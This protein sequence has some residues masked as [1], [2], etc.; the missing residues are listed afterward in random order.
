M[1]ANPRGTSCVKSFVCLLNLTLATI[2][3]TTFFNM[4]VQIDKLFVFLFENGEDNFTP[5]RSI[6]NEWYA[7]DMSRKMRSTLKI[8]N[9]L[10]YAIDQPPLSYIYDEMDKKR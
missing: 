2:V 5:F 1:S 3:F 4:L 7:K 6:M 8:K 9:S 10:G